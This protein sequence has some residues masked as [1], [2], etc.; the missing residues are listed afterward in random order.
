LKI[1]WKSCYP[2]MQTG[3]GQQ[4]ALILPRL[5]ALG[6]EVAVS[7]DY[8]QVGHTSFWNGIGVFGTSGYTMMGEDTV[9]GDAALF[10]ADLVITFLCTWQLQHPEVWRNLRT[11]HLMNVDCDPMSWGDYRVITDTG[12]QPAATS[13][14]GWEIMRAGGKTGANPADLREPLDPLYLP[15]GIDLN[16]Y[17]PVTDAKRAE[18][19]G[20]M[21]YDGKFV[22]GMNF[23]N[24][25]RL[26]DRK[27]LQ[28]QFRGF[29][30]FHAKHPDSL[31]VLNAVD[32]LPDGWHLSEMLDH[33]GLSGAYQFNP[34]YHIVAGQLPAAQLA[35]WYRAQDVYLGAGN[36]GVGLPGMEAQ[37]CGTPAILL[38]AGSGPELAG[39]C[40]WLVGNPDNPDHREFNEVHRA[41]WIRAPVTEVCARL[42]AAYEHYW[43]TG[44]GTRARRA[45]ERR[46]AV[47]EH[48]K[49]W[50]INRIV[51]EHWEPALAELA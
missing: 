32:G 48:A 13:R 31:L 23:H 43:L 28:R 7:C 9:A 21:G 25:D 16:C 35:D 30:M 26:P 46:E 17:S 3:Y 27:N 34:A 15:H 41:D 38:N 22:V 40:N 20:E 45:K 11:L 51:R 2:G 29:A 49:A 44:D 36:E 12:G 42:E 6:H 1:L 39:D 18:M 4:S 14:R 50:D 37:A 47:A 5:K 10:S 24:Q 33:F 8:G 19:R